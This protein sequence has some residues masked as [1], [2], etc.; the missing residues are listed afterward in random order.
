MLQACDVNDKSFQ[1]YLKKVVPVKDEKQNGFI[2]KRDIEHLKKLLKT[3]A[4]KLV[5]GK[6]SP[7]SVD[8][9]WEHFTFTSQ[10]I[11]NYKNKE[12]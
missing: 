12:N 11:E 1:S 2:S 7:P 3:K 9:N 10:E 6:I 4:N 8:Q 5:D